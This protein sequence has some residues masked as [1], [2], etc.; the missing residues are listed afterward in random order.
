MFSGIG[1]ST[2]T[3]ITKLPGIFSATR[4]EIE[5]PNVHENTKVTKDF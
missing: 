5:D 2:Q 3:V 4:L 1:N